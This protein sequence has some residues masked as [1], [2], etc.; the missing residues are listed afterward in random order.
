V[1]NESKYRMNIHSR[2]WRAG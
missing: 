1:N 2:G